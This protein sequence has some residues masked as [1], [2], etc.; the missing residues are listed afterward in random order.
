MAFTDANGN[1]LTKAQLL[2]KTTDVTY[3]ADKKFSEPIYQTFTTRGANEHGKGRRVK[4]STN[5]VVKAAD[6]DALYTSGT[7]TS[8]SPTTALPA[9]GGTKI[10]VNG[11]G[12]DGATG[13]TV[14]GTAATNFK[15]VNDRQVTFNTPAKA[16]GTHAL[17]ITDDGGN[18]S[19]G[20]LVFV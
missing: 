2:A 17:V 3:P 15:I 6:I 8:A 7:F 4:F 20:N 16:A 12:F 9:A 11:T 5:Q 14:G 18:V 19:A 13:A 10:T 1:V